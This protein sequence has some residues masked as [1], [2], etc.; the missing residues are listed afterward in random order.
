MR[1]VFPSSPHTGPF[2]VMLEQSG[3]QTQ[4][5]LFFLFMRHFFPGPQSTFSH[6]SRSWKEAGIQTKARQLAG[7]TGVG[8]GGGLKCLAQ[9]CIRDG[10][11]QAVYWKTGRDGVWGSQALSC[12]QILSKTT[13]VG[14]FHYHTQLRSLGTDL[15]RHCFAYSASWIP[16]S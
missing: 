3:A 12:I 5:G 8:W 4:R 7:Q 14:R 15:F 13:L 9:S 11:P 10:G 16:P 6:V 1:Y 2:Q